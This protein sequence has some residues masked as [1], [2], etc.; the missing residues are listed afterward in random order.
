[1]AGRAPRGRSTSD[2]A[3]GGFGRQFF[4]R[5]LSPRLTADSDFSF[6][7]LDLRFHR[8]SDVIRQVWDA[9]IATAFAQMPAVFTDHASPRAVIRRDKNARR[10]RRQMQ[11]KV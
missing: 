8:A 9:T 2:F 3:D 4:C 1:M 7:S 6:R 5:F 10:T 11:R